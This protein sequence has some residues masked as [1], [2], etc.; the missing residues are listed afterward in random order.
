MS[1]LFVHSIGEFLNQRKQKQ[2]TTDC[3]HKKARYLSVLIQL[4]FLTS[5]S[6]LDC[7]LII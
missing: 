2:G 7:I 5:D 1:C 3:I 6:F 4:A